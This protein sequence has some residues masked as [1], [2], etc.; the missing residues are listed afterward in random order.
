MT[1]IAGRRDRIVGY[2]DLFDT[3]DTYPDATYHALDHAGHYLPFEQPVTFAGLVRE[4]LTRSAISRPA[5]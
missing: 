2:L 3:L 1:L 4:W 5:G